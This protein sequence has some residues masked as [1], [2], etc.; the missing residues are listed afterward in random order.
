MRVGGSKTANVLR[1]WDFGA[2]SVVWVSRL[3]R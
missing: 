1:Q 3:A 2:G